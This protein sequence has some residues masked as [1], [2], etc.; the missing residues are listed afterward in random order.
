MRGK[1]EGAVY[2]VPADRSKPLKYWTGGIELPSHDG[3]RRRLPI[4]RKNKAELLA[5]SDEQRQDLTN[6]VDLPPKDQAH[7]RR[8]EYSHRESHVHG[9]RPKNA[10]GNHSGIKNRILPTSGKTKLANITPP[11]M[12][13]GTNARIDK[14]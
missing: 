4:R 14:G 10:G 12:S 9:T 8:Y 2:R 5:A 13:E 6:R 1:G 11:H 7:E 3:T